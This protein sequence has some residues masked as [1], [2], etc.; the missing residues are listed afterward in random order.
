MKIERT[1]NIDVADDKIVT[2]TQTGNIYRI[3]YMT[4]KITT[5]I[6][7][8]DENHYVEIA[9]GEVKEYKH[10]KTTRAE[11]AESTRKTFER[12][13]DLIN[14]N[15]TNPNRCLFVTLTYKENMKDVKRLYDDFRKFN[16]RFDTYCKNKKF[17]DYE[18]ISIV[19]PQ[20]RG[21]W[22]CHVIYIFSKKAPFIPNE[23]IA[24]VWKNGFTSTK[25]IKGNV[26]N[27]GVYLTAYLT[28]M[29]IEDIPDV[30]LLNGI[31]ADNIKTVEIIDDNGNK[32]NKSY[33]K[34]LRLKMYPKGTNIYRHSN[35]IIQ[36]KVTQCSK[37][38]AMKIIGSATKTFEKTISL[39]D[40]NGWEISKINYQYFNKNKKA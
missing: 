19:E 37:S 3:R 13:R 18:Y 7:K 17:P 33:I 36:P 4:S 32:T 25:H 28:D 31:N 29:Q 23:D 12:L 21:A 14:A 30:S 9:T 11:N 2:L 5:H 26:D 24:D 6:Q 39:T 8:I 40:E 34:G 27:V 10:D 15:V 35:G 38:E 22:H 20:G 1:D 16:M